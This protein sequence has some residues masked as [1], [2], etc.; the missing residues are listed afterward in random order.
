LDLPVG[1]PF[2]LGWDNL[3]LFKHHIKEIIDTMLRGPERLIVNDFMQIR[4]SR[5]D[6]RRVYPQNPSGLPP[7]P[8]ANRFEY[9]WFF[10]IIFRAGRY[11]VHRVPPVTTRRR[12]P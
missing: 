8:A 6:A 1:T 5:E 3:G 9:P 2:V 10:P 4:Y 12:S 11:V 7:I